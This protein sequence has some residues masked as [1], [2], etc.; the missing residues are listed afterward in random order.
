MLFRSHNEEKVAENIKV[1]SSCCLGEIIPLD[2]LSNDAF[3]S[4]ILGDGFGIKPVENCFLSP[5]AGV[6]K[7]VSDNSCEVT[8][9]TD[10]GFIL[11]VSVGSDSD[12]QQLLDVKCLVRP[13]DH[14]L[15]DTEIWNIDIDEYKDKG[16]SVVAAVIVTNANNI[17]SFN[18]SYGKVKK[19]DQPVMTITV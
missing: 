7:D 6:I 10:D 1:I 15:H 3:S 2:R 8:V 5:C 18:I 11:I 14:V 13:G 17:P 12:S 4:M 9:K 19:L 16:I